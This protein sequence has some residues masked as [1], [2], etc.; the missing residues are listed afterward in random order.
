METNNITATLLVE[1]TPAEVFAAVNNPRKWWSGEFEGS[2]DKLNDEFTYRYKDMHYSK[3]QVIEMLPNEKVVWLVTESYLSFL[4][5][6]EEWTGTKIIF[7]IGRE[8]NKTKL[9]FT[10]QGLTPDV[11]CYGACS[12][13]WQQLVTQSLYGFITT[14]KEDKPVLA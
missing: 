4:E 11:E 8:G 14:G 6:K 5:D 12:G 2:T 1:Q 9:R 3:Q 10:H 13:A 7:E